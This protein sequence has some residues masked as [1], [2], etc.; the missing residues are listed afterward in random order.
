MD[1]VKLTVS[2]VAA[3]LGESVNVVRNWFRDFKTYIPHDKSSGGYNLFTQDSMKVFTSIQKMT[4]E[5]NLTTR[6][7]EAILSGAVAPTVQE[8]P[9]GLNLREEI[10]DLKQMMQRQNEFNAALIQKLDEQREQMER[11]VD[12]RDGELLLALRDMRQERRNKPWWK[13]LLKD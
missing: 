4:R 2:Q 8:E 7:V 13:R 12:R 1:E 5:Q 11:I 10:A 9:D 3:T 6:Q